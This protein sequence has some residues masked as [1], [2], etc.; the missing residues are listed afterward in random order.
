MP[1][2]KSPISADLQT[3]YFLRYFSRWGGRRDRFPW[4][5]SRGGFR[6]TQLVLLSELNVLSRSELL[7]WLLELTGTK[8]GLVKSAVPLSLRGGMF[9]SEMIIEWQTLP[10]S[11]GW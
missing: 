10:F 9:K 2:W 11:R 5:D 7:D 8:E 6:S 3:S 4:S 1:L